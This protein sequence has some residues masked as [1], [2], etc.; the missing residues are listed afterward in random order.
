MNTTI[1]A[2]LAVIG[3]GSGGLSVAAGAAQMGA[4]VVLVE[5]GEMGG[6]CLNYGCVPSKS[7]LAAAHAPK[8]YVAVG[9]LAS[10]ATSP[11]SGSTRFTNT[12]T[13]SSPLSRRMTPSSVSKAWACASYGHRLGSHRLTKSRQASFESK[14]NGLWSRP[15]RALPCPRYRVSPTL[16]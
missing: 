8:Q 12:Y 15:A 10:M 6:D 13:T 5:K 16:R 2:D 1:K 7:L 3:A 11:R 4:D 14:R 9:D